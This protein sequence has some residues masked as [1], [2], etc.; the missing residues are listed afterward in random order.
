MANDLLL[1]VRMQLTEQVLG[2]LRKITSSTSDTAKALK[3]ARDRLKELNK[4]QGMVDDLRKQQ[5]ALAANSQQLKIQ[6]ALLQ[7]LQNSGTATEAQLKKQSAAVDRQTEAWKRQAAQ[8]AQM[9]TRANG[10]GLG[11]ISDDQNRIEREIKETTAAIEKQSAA[12]KAQGEQA[13]K[14]NALRAKHN[15]DMTRV[16]VTAAAGAAGVATGR[17]IASPL[18]S[19]FGAYGDQEAASLQL[20]AAMMKSDGSV[21]K[22]L[23]EI[24]DLAT[25][26]GDRLPG[27]TAEFQQMMT[28]LVR[29]GMPAKTILGGLG[30]AAAYL[31]VQLQMPVTEA[32]EFASK[33]QD[34]TRTV[35][36]DMMGLMDT[37]QRAHYLGVDSDNMLQGFT[38]MSPV[39]GLLRQEGLQAAN[40]LAPLLVMM[41][42]TGMAGES[43]GNAIRKVFQA[44]MDLKKVDKANDLLK[45][46]KAGFKLDFT[47]GKGN[48]GGLDKV[49]AQIKKLEKLNDT[50]R[51]SVMKAVF[52]D[53]SETLQVVST[54]MSKGLSG[55]QEVANKMQAQADLRKRVNEEL[56]SLKN[57]TE[58]AQGSWTNAMSSLVTSAAP[59]I[60]VIVKWIGELGNSISAWAAEN[61]R[62]SGTLV[63]VLGGL[64]ALLTVVGT[65]MLAVAGAAAPLLAMRFALATIGIKGM[66]LAGMFRNIG[67]AVMGLGR[68]MMAN[69][70]V[71]I[72][73]AIAA[74]AYLIYRNWDVIGPFFAGL[75]AGITATASAAWSWIK[76]AFL[77]FTP[78]GLIIQNWGGITTFFRGLWT[79][80]TAAAS[81]GWSWIRNSFL[82]F[83]PMG[84]IIQ[85]WGGITTFFNNLWSSIVSGLAALPARLM[86]MGGMLMDGLVNGITSRITAVKDAIVNVASSTVGWFK[87]KLGIKSPSRVFMAAG[88]EISNG[89]AKGIESQQGGVLAAARGMATVAASVLPMF[90]GPASAAMPA[91]DG[92]PPITAASASGRAASAAPAAGNTYAITIQAAPGMDPQAIARAVSAELDRRERS[93]QATG[94][95]QLAD[96]D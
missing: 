13:K 26:L 87:E 17:A 33:M 35:D 83:T 43:A 60:K 73:A 66:P 67:S 49:F 28:M 1:K 31:G 46:A 93:R 8:M 30:E 52:G 20:R 77:N 57:V 51:T 41:D 47:D 39:M 25:R 59:A 56:G 40:S 55:Y 69:P 54:M 45:D 63:M 95:S 86:A 53:D 11:K 71:L 32:A 3:A 94:R 68:I 58:A 5:A 80:I 65:L 44:G 78:M 70:I 92:R 14:L 9:R 50:D 74:A 18:Q 7:S 85:N 38:K 24:T 16:G 6:K 42:Q 79:G 22:E 75:W 21:P 23:K 82:N 19:A 2:P 81:A 27:T 36:K 12:F 96:R 29:Q 4:Q 34:A 37:I 76:S 62:L 91:I 64:A 84:L 72:V 89:A 61:P 15:K 10:M 90:T 48:F 88:G